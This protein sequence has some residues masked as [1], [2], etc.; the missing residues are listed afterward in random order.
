V[1]RDKRGIA[2]AHPI[3]KALLQPG[4]LVEVVL[5]GD[6]L[7]NRSVNRA[8]GN[9]RRALLRLG[10]KV[11]F[12]LLP[13]PAPGVGAGLDDWLMRIDAADRQRAFAALPRVD[14]S[15]FDED[16]ASVA[17]FFELATNKDG[18]ATNLVT[19]IRKIMQGHEYFATRYYLDIMRG[20]IYRDDPHGPAA[21]DDSFI[22]DEQCW[23]ETRF[24]MKVS[25]QGM[26]DALRWMAKQPRWHRNTLLESLP[27]WDGVS[28]LETMFIVGLGAPDTP[29]VRAAG[30]RW[31]VSAMARANAP[32][33]QVDT[34]L[35]LVGKQG[36]G[37]SRALEALA[38][39]LYVATHTQVQDKDFTLALDR[40]W[41]IDMA[42]L[43]SMNHSDA[44]HIKGIITTATDHIRPPYA[45]VIERKPRHCVIVGT[46]NEDRFLRDQTGN[47]RFW[48]VQCGKVDLPWLK[49]NGG[50][51]RAEAQERYLAGQDWWDMPD[52][53]AAEQDARMEIGAWDAEL[54]R[55]LNSTDY[56]RV[57]AKN[58]QCYRFITS[59]ELLMGLGLEPWKRKSH[60]YRDLKAAME[61]V[62]PHWKKDICHQ[63]I[64]IA[65]GAIV[66]GV[67][68][69]WLPTVANV[70]A[71]V[72]DLHPPS[73]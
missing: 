23:F 46:T 3:I 25:K 6:I 7:T 29:H 31:L 8:G 26:L 24:G 42:E 20:N 62:A 30:L 1:R 59:E 56:S 65:G 19:N 22:F 44:N 58:G 39:G 27:A 14:G 2:H 64:S 49:A 47:R 34:M 71:T 16:W 63:A 72:V 55:I 57:V 51:L 15:E 36:I 9:L 67:N 10:V 5:D 68:G 33:C 12:V 61:R 32:G 43:S 4:D 50:Q 35:V 38:A 18:I 17:D 13:P 69:Y 70:S 28:R 60:M 52:E 37:K 53:T 41:L 54:V 21:F 45:A 66:S 11:R 48:P 73:M 40:G